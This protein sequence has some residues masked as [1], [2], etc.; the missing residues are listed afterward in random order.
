MSPLLIKSTNFLFISLLFF[1]YAIDLHFRLVYEVPV[2]KQATSKTFMFSYVLSFLC[3]IL[4]FYVY[5]FS[6]FFCF[7]LL[8]LYL[9]P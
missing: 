9:M 3:F 2:Q 4:Y 6:L 5:F 1:I 7:V 8:F